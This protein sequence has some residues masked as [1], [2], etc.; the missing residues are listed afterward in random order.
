MMVLYDTHCHLNSENFSSD[1]EGYLKRAKEA[2][3]AKFA[4]I[5]WDLVSSQK[6]IELAEKFEEVYAVVGI[7][8]SDVFKS[9]ESDFLA[10]EELL[11]HPKVVALGEIGLDYYWHK[12]SMEHEVQKKYFIKQIEIANKMKMPVVIH[13]RDASQDTL[14]ILRKYPVKRGGVMH[15]FSS[16]LE[17]AREFIK[18]DFYIGLGGPLTFKNAKEPKRVAKEIP[19]EKI[20]IETDSPYLAPHPFRGKQNESSYLPLVLEELASIKEMEKEKVADILMQ[21]SLKLFHVELQ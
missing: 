16:S 14:E 21:N 13:M 7:H 15:C 3:V 2:G 18:L 11:K 5:G 20:V 1:I 12:E 6:A 19:L 4:V 17:M 9:Q 8:P 10:I